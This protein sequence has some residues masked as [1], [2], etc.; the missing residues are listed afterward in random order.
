MPRIPLDRIR[1]LG[2]IAHVDAG[3][4]TL[5]ERVLLYTGRIHAA[6]EV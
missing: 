1:N 5:T 3:K 2:I 4:T 6:G